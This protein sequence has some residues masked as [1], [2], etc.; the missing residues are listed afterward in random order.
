MGKLIGERSVVDMELLLLLLRKAVVIP[1][2][3]FRSMCYMKK[4]LVS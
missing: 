4:I 3:L 1:S 2:N